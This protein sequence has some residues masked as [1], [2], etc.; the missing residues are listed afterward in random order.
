MQIDINIVGWDRSSRLV[1]KWTRNRLLTIVELWAGWGLY[2]FLRP[3]IAVFAPN[4]DFGKKA[5]LD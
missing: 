3:N 4:F 5:F 2:I 1:T